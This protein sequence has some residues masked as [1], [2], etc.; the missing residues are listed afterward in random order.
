MAK[1]QRSQGQISSEKLLEH[2]KGGLNLV[3][4]GEPVRWPDM[5]RRL[6]AYKSIRPTFILFPTKLIIFF[7]TIN[8]FQPSNGALIKSSALAWAFIYCSSGHYSFNIHL[9]R[10]ETFLSKILRTKLDI[11]LTNIIRKNQK[12]E[13]CGLRCI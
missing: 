12:W 10:E 3:G 1:V 2:D 5:K 6:T 9:E 8:P 13:S 11:S 4:S 7:K